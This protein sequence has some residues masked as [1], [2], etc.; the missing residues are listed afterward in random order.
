MGGRQH[1][2]DYSVAVFQGGV[3]PLSDDPQVIID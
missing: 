2:Y 3:P 1:T